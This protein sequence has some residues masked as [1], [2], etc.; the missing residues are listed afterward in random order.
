M[1]KFLRYIRLAKE[2]G[3]QAGNKSTVRQIMEWGLLF[4]R[5]RLGPGFYYLA[6][7]QRLDT[8]T[9]QLLGYWSLRQY[10][11][12]VNE[13]NER[14]YHRS[15]QNK[16]V[17][18]AILSSYGIPTP[19]LL[20]HY[21]PVRGFSTTGEPLRSQSD[22][23]RLLSNLTPG[24][25]VCFKLT[26][27]WG[28]NGFRAV[29]AGENNTLKDLHSGEI[30]TLDDYLPLLITSGGEGILLERYLVQH[31][32]FARFNPSSVNSLR[33]MITLDT[34]GQTVCHLVFLRVGSLGSLVDNTQSGGMLYPVDLQSGC[35]QAG[36]HK[37][38]PHL[39]YAQNPGTG[40]TMAGR[41]V[42]ML[43]E[44]LELAGRSILAFPGIRFSGTDI[45]MSLSG[46]VVLEQN[47]LPDYSGF[48]HTRVPSR[49]VLKK[50][51]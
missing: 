40:E 1:G 3:G 6:K 11:R 46:P 30:Y 23:Q 44:A 36:Y 43:S 39:L 24:S 5:S 51:N 19:E 15:S 2:L 45:A 12:R 49:S 13:Y 29:E 32:E 33:C 35:L 48:A 25:R 50:K 4:L 22:L 41:P 17:E 10:H 27:S 31:P 47:I 8:S 28:G 18:K 21:H 37:N 16:V 38:A 20:G 14:L 9:Q 26:E 34:Q 7:M 42:P